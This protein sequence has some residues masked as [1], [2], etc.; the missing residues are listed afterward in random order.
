MYVW[1]SLFLW[2]LD[3]FL[4]LVRIVLVNSRLISPGKRG[5][6]RTLT[7]DATVEILSPHFLRISIPFPPYFEWSAGQ[8]AYLTLC[9][10]Y[11]TSISEAHPFT[12]SNAPNDKNWTP[13]EPSSPSS[14]SAEKSGS[15]DL[16]K[17]N[18][19]SRVPITAGNLVFILRV[20]HGFTK[21]LLK[22]VTASP[23]G[24]EQT[25]KAFV[26]GPYSSP[27]IVRG[28]DTVVLFGGKCFLSLNCL[29]LIKRNS[30]GS[31]VS[32]VLPFLLDLIQYVVKILVGIVAYLRTGLQ[33]RIRIRYA[34][35]S[36]SSGPSGTQVR[37]HIPH[38]QSY[39]KNTR[40]PQTKLNG[41]RTPSLT[42]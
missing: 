2:G 5:G 17:E 7:S 24:R 11:P 34:G 20:R 3:R 13:S 22:A 28:Y 36:S 14:G 26:D 19:K 40:D 18:E 10:A 1:P 4:R 16:P 38:R 9:G 27:P 12:I 21:R 25:Y 33:P 35:G 30:G 37:F 29:W 42:L 8:S 23:N 15:V 39:S 31:G 41:S 6:P 32:F